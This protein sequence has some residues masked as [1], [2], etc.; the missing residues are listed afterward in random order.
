MENKEMDNGLELLKKVIKSNEDNIEKLI[1]ITFTYE[2][3]LNLVGEFENSAKILIYKIEKNAD[4]LSEIN[5]SIEEN[6]HKIPETIQANLSENSLLKLENFETKSKSLKYLLWGNLGSLVM[7]ILVM[8]LSFY[9]SKK[10]YNESIKTKEEIR[11][12]IFEE[13][14][15]QGKDF[16]EIEKVNRLEMNTKIIN[17]WIEKN[18][19]EGSRF[20]QFKEGYETK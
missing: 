16:Y 8:I 20:L 17:K 14:R 12:E 2:D 1:E 6:I 7:A 9:F 19:K 5:Q 15:N 13:M 18:P 11:S 3:M 4:L 10:W